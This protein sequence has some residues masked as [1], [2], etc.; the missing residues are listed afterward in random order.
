MLISDAVHKKEDVV[1]AAMSK[2]DKSYEA[3]LLPNKNE[4]LW[5]EGLKRYIEEFVKFL[6]GYSIN[7]GANSTPTEV[8]VHFVQSMK[9]Y[10][11]M[12]QPLR[13]DMSDIPMVAVALT[14]LAYD[15]KRYVPHTHNAMGYAFKGNVSADGKTVKM[16]DADTPIDIS[17][18]ATMWGKLYSDLFQ[19]N[20]YIVKQ[21]H[22][23]AQSY[24]IVDNNLTRIEMKSQAD[25]SELEVGTNKD[26]LLRW[27]YDFTVKALMTEPSHDVKTVWTIPITMVDGSDTYLD[28]YNGDVISPSV[29]NKKE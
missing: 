17:F 13:N 4:M 26:R 16:K 22:H 20:Y 10:A 14:S 27:S 1:Y 28:K 9:Q 5:H 11:E 15:Q 25:S 29:A 2:F 19:W 24:Y 8:K 3:G 23:G 18:K 21:F 7:R 6:G 12:L